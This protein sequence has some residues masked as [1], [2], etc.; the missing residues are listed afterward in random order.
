MTSEIEEHLARSA[1]ELEAAR[2]LQDVFPAQS[3]THS[4][5]AAFFAAEAA[6]LALGETRS[7]HSGVLSAFGRLLMKTGEVDATLG[8]H[9][10]DLFELRL[11]ATYGG[12]SVDA[13]TAGS[14]TGDARAFVDAVEAWLRRRGA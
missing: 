13:Q 14:A 2:L 9:L 1:Q 10:R 11:G 8:S 12:R 3:V 7:K 5:Y 6:L 4:Y